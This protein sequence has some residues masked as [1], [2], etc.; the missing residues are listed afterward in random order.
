[1]PLA[2]PP[3]PPT[4]ATT[5]GYMRLVSGQDAL[6]PPVA[7]STG[8]CDD[9]IWRNALVI[10]EVARGSA[11][12]INVDLSQR[13]ALASK[14][15]EFCEWLVR[16]CSEFRR[17]SIPHFAIYTVDLSHTGIGNLDAEK[18]ISSIVKI[19]PQ[20]RVLKLFANNLSDPAPFTN[21]LGRGH[22]D[23]LHLSNNNFGAPAAASIIAAAS[24][25]TND[26]DEPLYPRG[27]VRPLWLRLENNPFR[28]SELRAAMSLHK[29]LDVK[30]RICTLDRDSWCS[31]HACRCLRRAPAMH[32]AYVRL[33]GPADA[34]SEDTSPDAGTRRLVKPKRET[35]TLAVPHTMQPLD[36]STPPP[37]NHH[38]M[39]APWWNPDGP[40]G[41]QPPCT[42]VP[43]NEEYPELLDALN[44]KRVTRQP[45]V[46]RTRPAPETPPSPPPNTP[47]PHYDPVGEG[48]A[49]DLSGP[50]GWLSPMDAL[51]C[52]VCTHNYISEAP[53]YLSVSAG[54]AVLLCE[55][56]GEAYIHAFSVRFQSYGLLPA[57]VVS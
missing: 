44:A 11:T 25:A 29:G 36:S 38:W 19:N 54:D 21:L 23:E 52:K 48:E 26:V 6:K 35:T 24:S 12:I 37:P 45:P 40:R 42:T 53:G 18:L 41:R 1:M 47:M 32:L 50:P 55:K 31:P 27:A 20:V 5:R 51:P 9:D 15:V 17:S 10:E 2:S 56:K 3:L 14:T 30:K 4:M 8:K 22:L 16:A 39:P 46:L 7:G 13:K 28:P 57:R 49:I 43:V 34:T 33:L